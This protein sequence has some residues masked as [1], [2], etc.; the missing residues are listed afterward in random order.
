MA[1]KPNK[2]IVYFVVT[3][4][5]VFTVA[6]VIVAINYHFESI[7]HD[8][9]PINRIINLN[10]KDDLNT[11][12]MHTKKGIITGRIAE[13]NSESIIVSKNQ[14][15]WKITSDQRTIFRVNNTNST[16]EQLKINDFITV[17]GDTNSN[18]AT[19]RA[20]LIREN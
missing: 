17:L 2:K 9:G 7:T 1:K 8:S 3:S 5:A 11:I 15:T 14:L 13:I 6:V 10:K 4:A 19:I 20:V 12:S 16:R 18:E